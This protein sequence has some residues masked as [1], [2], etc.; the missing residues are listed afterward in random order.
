MGPCHC[1]L[2]LNLFVC[3]ILLS[4]EVAPL[5]NMCL[6]NTEA[7]GQEVLFPRREPGEREDAWVRFPECLLQCRHCSFI[8]LRGF[9]LERCC[10][11][12]LDRLECLKLLIC[13]CLPYI[14]SLRDKTC[15]S[16]ACGSYNVQAAV[17]LRSSL[18][19]GHLRKDKILPRD[20]VHAGE[21]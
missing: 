20:D 8:F 16:L 10:D 5:G 3:T 15:L 19:V 7:V 2:F 18:F 9:D 17:A 6:G 12:L 1:H 21:A 4:I 13:L 11:W 14:L